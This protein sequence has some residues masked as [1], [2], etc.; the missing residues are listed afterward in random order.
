[1]VHSWSQK[2]EVGDLTRSWLSMRRR[3]HTSHLRQVFFLGPAAHLV[4]QCSA[5]SCLPRSLGCPWSV[6]C[7]LAQS[8]VLE[9]CEI[10]CTF[11]ELCFKESKN[12]AW[13]SEAGQVLPRHA[14]DSGPLTTHTHTHAPHIYM[15]EIGE[16]GWVRV[17]GGAPNLFASLREGPCR[18]KWCGGFSWQLRQPR[19]RHK[20]YFARS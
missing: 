4:C 8:P 20:A 3:R 14:A 2:G 10:I 1:M 7:P 15:C 9:S 17:H 6:R 16:G 13:E 19:M 12:G 18:K 5:K 11:H